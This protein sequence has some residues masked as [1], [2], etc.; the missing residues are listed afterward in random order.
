[1]PKLS[2][3]KEK[4][5]LIFTKSFTE[6]SQK[7]PQVLSE[8]SCKKKQKIKNYMTSKKEKKC[9]INYPKMKKKLILKNPTH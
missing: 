9:G 3:K 1:M 5:L 6:L 8:F 4:S 7:D 2:T